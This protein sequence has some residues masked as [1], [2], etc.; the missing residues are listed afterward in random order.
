MSTQ[1]LIAIPFA[2]SITVVVSADSRA[3]AEEKAK[4][5]DITVDISP[6]DNVRVAA[7]RKEKISTGK[8][9]YVPSYCVEKT[10]P[11]DK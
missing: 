11:R 5:V 8:Q 6:D 4:G 9:R 1:H 7:F 10:N 2:G 3:D